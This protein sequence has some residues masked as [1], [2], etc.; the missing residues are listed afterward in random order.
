MCQACGGLTTSFP[1]I[2]STRAR[3]NRVGARVL[4]FPMEE[5]KKR[6]LE[7]E[8]FK[9]RRRRG[10]AAKGDQANGKICD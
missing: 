9:R 3:I 2:G 5:E 4:A 10:L 8:R 6:G 1:W 7:G